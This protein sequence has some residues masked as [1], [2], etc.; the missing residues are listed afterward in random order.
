MVV[1]WSD[2][3][4]SL[5]EIHSLA[6][7]QTEEQLTSLRWMTSCIPSRKP[8]FPNPAR[9]HFSCSASAPPPHDGAGL[10]RS[11]AF[12]IEAVK[13]SRIRQVEGEVPTPSNRAPNAFEKGVG[14]PTVSSSYN[15]VNIHE[16]TAKNRVSL[17]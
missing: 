7:V 10:R 13:P 8:L 11:S 5:P 2:P 15:I 6:L 12:S 17:P 14:S 3:C 1:N 16:I 4:A 9:P